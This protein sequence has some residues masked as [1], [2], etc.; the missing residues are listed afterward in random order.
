LRAALKLVCFVLAALIAGPPAGWSGMAFAQSANA[1]I[2]LAQSDAEER[3]QPGLFRFLFGRNRKKVDTQTDKA[4]ERQKSRKATARRRKAVASAPKAVAAVEKAADAKRVVV[5]GDFM[6]KALAKGLGEAF[7]ENTGILVI[8]ASNGSSGLVR[9]DFYD[10]NARLPEI[11]IAENAELVVVMIGA[12]DRQEIRS[13]SGRVAKGTPKWSMAYGGRVAALI[14]AIAAAGKPALWVGLVPVKSN[15]LS[16]DYSTFNSIYREKTDAAG[17]PFVETWNGFSDGQGRYVTSGPDINGQQR[18]LR[19]KDGLNFTRAGRRKLAFFVERDV[20]RLLKSD[21]IPVLAAL[22]PDGSRGAVKP[23]RILIG[24][25]VPVDAVSLVGNSEL[26]RFG[27][28]PRTQSGA[29]IET[30]VSGLPADGGGGEP[31]AAPP[32]WPPPGRV[33]DFRWTGPQ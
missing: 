15:T 33:D 25:L 22:A 24:P 19:T 23:Q 6:G 2:V 8:D 16:R 32:L 26:S 1:P 9:D 29:A 11:A 30:I 21:A 17:I 27:T 5:V 10:W 12:N 31:A 13:A 7:A 28:T 14:Q 20:L 4:G 3:R 18:G